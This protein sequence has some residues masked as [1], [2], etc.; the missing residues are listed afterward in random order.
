MN[1]KLPKE[2]ITCEITAIESLSRAVVETYLKIESISKEKFNENSQIPAPPINQTEA[3][4]SSGE[5]S[6]SSTQTD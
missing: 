4:T 2:N 1:I 6:R 3:S 5:T